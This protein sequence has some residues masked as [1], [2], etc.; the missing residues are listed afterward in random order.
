MRRIFLVL[1]VVG[2]AWGQETSGLAFGRVGSAGAEFLSVELSPRAEGLGGAYTASVLDP[3]SPFGNPAGVNF[4]N[5]RSL[6][7]SVLPYWV[8][9][10]FGG[11]AYIHPLDPYQ[12]VYGFARFM[13]SGGFEGFSVLDDGTIQDLG[14]FSV[15]DIAAG[16]GYAR[17]YTDRAVMAVQV[18]TVYERFG[19]FTS[20]LGVALDVGSV[21]DLKWKGFRFGMAMRNL[22]PDLRP[23]GKKYVYRSGS[24]ESYDPY[25]LPLTFRLGIS[26]NPLEDE[27]QR[28]TVAADL[29]HPNNQAERFFFGAEYAYAG[30]FFLRL[31]YV[32]GYGGASNSNLN[33]VIH[34]GV[35]FR[36][37][38]FQI[39]YSFTNARLAPDL[40]RIGF[41]QIFGQ[42]GAQ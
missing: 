21:Y 31:G 16:V 29:E 24:E 9:T 42:G 36:V 4:V 15:S 39:D 5:E 41:T 32:T 26:L 19:D 8:S 34:A 3:S 20:A 7:V 2:L 6:F 22:G 14:T 11:I 10:Y 40:H 33:Q 17:R 35:G 12:R 18:K 23:G 13:N 25:P 27:V 37:G 1:S 28:L 38:Q 30:T